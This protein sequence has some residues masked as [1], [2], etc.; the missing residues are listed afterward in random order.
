MRKS[1]A[2]LLTLALLMLS[3]AA[4]AQFG[5]NPP[6]PWWDPQWKDYDNHRW[7][8]GEVS[9]TKVDEKYV[10]I[11]WIDRDNALLDENN[12]ARA[13]S[14]EMALQTRAYIPCYLEM[15][16]TGNEGQTILQS[17][18]P[19]ATPVENPNGYLLAFDN[20][21]GGFVDEFWNSLGHGR[22][23]EVNFTEGWSNVYIQ[24]CDVF[25]VEVYANDDYKYEVQA[26][27]LTPYDANTEAWEAVD[28]LNLQMRY[29]F[30]EYGLY[31]QTRTFDQPG[32]IKEIAVMDACEELTVYH[33]FR[34]PYSRNIA[35]GRYDGEVIFRA[36][37][38]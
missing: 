17:F 14:V 21:I 33:Q 13:Q 35:H 7:D 16:V 8:D 19:L 31:G 32:E 26:G 1:I 38:L 25:K 15:K 4:F 29:K 23:A 10:N 3:T 24:G 20:E 18:G 34:V 27:P 11:P 22:N 28:Q 12:P 30:G 5:G 9:W 37:T 36:Y 6:P 2:L